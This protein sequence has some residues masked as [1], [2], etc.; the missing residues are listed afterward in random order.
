MNFDFSDDVKMLREQAGDLLSARKS[1]RSARRSLDQE[2]EFDRDL[3][4]EVANLGWTGVAL[5]EEYGGYGIGFQGLCALAGELGRSLAPIPFSSSIYLAAESVLLCGSEAQKAT[6]LPKVADGSLIGTFALMEGIG[7]PRVEEIEARVRNGRLTGRKVAVPDGAIADFAV[8]A[9]RL[10]DAEIGLA[11]VELN[12]TGVARNKIATI[13]PT[14]NHATLEFDQA[15]CEPLAAD[16]WDRVLR[17]L[18]R[19][20]VLI[21]FEQVGG[22]EACLSMAQGHAV[23]RYAFGRPIGSFQAIK[24]KLARMFIGT[25][26]AKSNAYY[27]AWAA[28]GQSEEILT[29]AAAAARISASRAFEHAARENIQ[30]H[31]GMGFTWESDCHLFYRRAKSLSVCVGSVRFWSRQ[32]FELLDGSNAA[33]VASD[34]F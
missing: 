7:N 21:A 4:A 18:G 12:Q 29:R 6:W 26:L 1:I 14:R 17:V 31:G 22:A 33:R 25:E 34:G 10:E 3:W 19:A 24:H 32:L 28:D 11:I 20:A 15:E 9:A 30:T 8:V 23:N 27:G 2:Q 16:G 5:P 13:D